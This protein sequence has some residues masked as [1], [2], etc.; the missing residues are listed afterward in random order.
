MAML[1]SRIKKAL[2]LGTKSITANGTY[3]ASSDGYDG[4]S[5]VEVNVAG[6]TPTPITPSNASPAALTSGTAVSPTANGY[7][8]ESYSSITPSNSSPATITSGSIYKA[9]AN[10]KAVESVTLATPS[11]SDAPSVSNGEIVKIN[12]SSGKLIQSLTSIR[13]LADTQT[14]L[15][16]GDVYLVASNSSRGGTLV[17]GSI[18]TKTPS[19]SNPP[20][21]YSGNNY[22]KASASGYLYSSSGL[23]TLYNLVKSA[24]VKNGGTGSTNQSFSAVSGKYY[25]VICTRSSTSTPSNC[26]ISSGAT[27]DTLFID[28][29]QN[30]SSAAAKVKIWCAIVKATSSTITMLGTNNC[31]LY[32]QLT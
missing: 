5:S 23:G 7:A 6:V 18:V 32:M 24:T 26:G 12:G 2:N 29:I 1:L 9:S 30:I 28:N 20:A 8:I 17:G 3:N 25:L 19:D 4:Y 27:V 14:D 21:I 11:N 15:N 13:V 10:G 22:F 31:C 16:I